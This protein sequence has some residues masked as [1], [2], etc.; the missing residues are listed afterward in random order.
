MWW[1]TSG[2]TLKQNVFP[3]V[4]RAEHAQPAH[5]RGQ[6]SWQGVGLE[7]R[8]GANEWEKSRKSLQGYLLCRQLRYQLTKRKDPFY[9][10]SLAAAAAA[11]LASEQGGG[12]S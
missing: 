7:W 4:H 5:H 6:S 1:T 11:R 2:R 10:L 9:P 12:A 8:R 3:K